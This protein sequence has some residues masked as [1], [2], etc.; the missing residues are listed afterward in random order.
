MAHARAPVGDGGGGSGVSGVG[1]SGSGVVGSH[2][3]G[4]LRRAEA[5]KARQSMRDGYF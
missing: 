1:G 3:K 4:A 2:G 5:P